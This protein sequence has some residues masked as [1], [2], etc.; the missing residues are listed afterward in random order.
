MKIICLVFC[1]SLLGANLFGE[2]TEW[3]SPATATSE[4]ADLFRKGAE[5]VKIGKYEEAVKLF[6]SAN[7]KDKN[8]PEI[9]NMLAYSKR[10]LGRLDEALENYGQALKLRPKF[11]QA[12]EY[13]GEAHLQALLL[14]LQTLES[15]G[16]EGAKEAE[17]LKQSL[18]AAA[19]KIQK[20]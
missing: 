9:L 1:L 8:N 18:L 15:Y 6:E 19:A 14:Q 5:S 12:R 11:P 20:P 7:G 2:G 4:A 13:L 16:A 3:D 10:K 17:K